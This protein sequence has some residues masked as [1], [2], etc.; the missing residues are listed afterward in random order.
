MAPRVLIG[1]IGVALALFG[2]Y[3]PGPDGK[4]VLVVNLTGSPCA[5]VRQVG[6]TSEA[7]LQYA[8]E[9]EATG[10]IATTKL[11][12]I[13]D[14]MFLLQSQADAACNF[15]NRGRISFDQYRSEMER[16]TAAMIQIKSGLPAK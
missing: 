14:R 6:H 10:K 7:T 1:V 12:D 4:G 15:F 3:G 8:K 13:E 5:D 16:V 2:C 9:L 11:V